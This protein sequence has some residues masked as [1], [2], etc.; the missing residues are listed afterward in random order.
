MFRPIVGAIAAALCVGP[1][2]AQETLLFSTLSAG[3]TPTNVEVHEPWT[4]RVNAAAKGAIVIE[5]RHGPV[6]ANLRNVYDR[7]LNDVVQIGWG[8]QYLVTN[9]FHL[10]E[11][12]ALPF[13]VEPSEYKSEYLSVALWRMYKSGALDAEYDQIVPLYLTILTQSEFHAAKPLKTLDNWSGLRIIGPAP[14]YGA[15]ITAMG[16]APLSFAANEYYEA[17][18]RGAADGVITGFTAFPSFKLQEVTTYHVNVGLGTAA[19]MVFMAKKRWG[20]LPEAGRRAI[21]ES[22][23][24]EQSRIFGAFW[25]RQ[26]A[27]VREQV[28]KMPGHT[29]V[30]LSP[31]QYASW[32]AKSAGAID[33]LVKARPGG[34]VYLQAFR[35][36]VAAIRAEKMGG[37]K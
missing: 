4:N 17:L 26:D 6:L 33:A 16:A 8:L 11:I 24:E 10:T 20:A 12:G 32:P 9:K 3:T 15:V 34:E 30:E 36:E 1:V 13:V 19:G 27:G 2:G 5:Q 23:G 7:V 22:S 28:K 25:D 29:V 18:N 31:T 35:K 21:E 37:K 14:H